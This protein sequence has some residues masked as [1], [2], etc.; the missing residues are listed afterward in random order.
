MAKS[1]AAVAE[2]PEAT[3]AVAETSKYEVPAYIRQGAGRGNESVSTE[4]IQIPRLEVTQDLSPIVKDGDAEA[5]QLYNSVTGEVY[6]DTVLFTPIIFMKQYLVW[7]DRKAG[8]GFLGAFSSPEAAQARVNEAI[9]A[10]DNARFI[11]IVPTPIHYGLL[12]EP[13]GEGKFKM[14]EV[15]ISMPRSKEK[16]SKRFNSMVQLAE[17][18]RFSRVYQVGAVE[19]S[20]QAGDYYNFDIKPHG[21]APEEVYR[22]AEKIY[23]KVVKA[24]GINVNHEGAQEQEG[25]AA[26]NGEF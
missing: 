25:S 6:G 26:D 20:S 18:D 16:I 23:E 21:W 14:V 13:H 17:G 12:L 4:D 3:T 9:N 2:K 1:N 5:G 11:S 8:G 7:K 19:A 22:A 10:G 15:A 24:G